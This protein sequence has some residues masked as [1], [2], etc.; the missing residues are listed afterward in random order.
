MP[1][2]GSWELADV[3]REKL[4]TRR[5]RFFSGLVGKHSLQGGLLRRDVEQEGEVGGGW[6]GN[7]RPLIGVAD[8]N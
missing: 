1:R 2:G 3:P 5:D 7:D 6:G 4:T 8:F